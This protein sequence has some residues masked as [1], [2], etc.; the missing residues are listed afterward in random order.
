MLFAVILFFSYLFWYNLNGPSGWLPRSIGDH[1]CSSPRW[2]AVMSLQRNL[3]TNPELYV[4]L[5]RCMF[6]FQDGIVWWSMCVLRLCLSIIWRSVIYLFWIGPGCDQ[7]VSCGCAYN[8]L[9]FPNLCSVYIIYMNDYDIIILFISSPK[10]NVHRVISS[11]DYNKMH[12]QS[13]TVI[14]S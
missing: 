1:P 3:N 6:C 5:T 10:S 8:Q 14:T 2:P 12:L 9:Q 13:L 7:C 11:M 4:Q